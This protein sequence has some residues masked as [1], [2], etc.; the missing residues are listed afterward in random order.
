[1][2]G[3]KS[4]DCRGFVSQET[5]EIQKLSSLRFLCLLANGCRNDKSTSD[6][7]P[8][9]LPETT[10]LRFTSLSCCANRDPRSASHSD[11]DDLM[12]SD[13][14]SAFEDAVTL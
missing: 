3:A 8:I 14:S 13:E 7:I 11:L 12:A 2:M 9:R 5:T 1:M 6:S 10:I 4:A